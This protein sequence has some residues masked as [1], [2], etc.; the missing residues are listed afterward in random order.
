MTR[1]RLL[2][3]V[4]VATALCVGLAAPMAAI[5]TAQTTDSTPGAY[6]TV[7]NVSM[8]PENPEPGETVTVTAT[9]RNSE[10]SGGA[11]EIT[12]VSLQSGVSRLNTAHDLGS[13]GSGDSTE[14]PLSTTFDSEGEK[15]LTAVVRGVSPSGSVFAVEKPV[16]VDVERSSGV[17]LA[18]SK[19]YDVDAAAGA[20]TP[21]D[22]TVANGDSEAITG[23]QLDVDGADVENPDRITGSIDGG[24]EDTFQYDVT[25]DEVG[26]R[27]LSGEVTYTTA[28]GVTRTT[29]KTAD[30]EAVDPEIRADV[31]ARTTADGETEVELTNFGNARFTDVEVDA[32]ANGDVVAR[33]LLGD[34][35]PDSN[36]SVVFDIPSSIDGT[37]TYTAT[38]TAAGTSHT[39]S[40][41]DR[42]TV[43][44]EIRLVSVESSQSGS[45]VTVTGD[46]AN[47]GSTTAESVLVSVADTA[48]VSPTAPTGEYYVGEVEGS[49]FGTF[50]LT[51]ER[52]PSAESVPVEITYVVDGDRVTTTQRIDL[53]GTGGEPVA[54]SGDG[55]GQGQGQ[56]ANGQDPPGGPGGGLP[57]P[58]IGVALALLVVA[59]GVGVYRWRNR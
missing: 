59:A 39:T 13:L 32:T 26:T 27:T 57:L 28:E 37:V 53:G 3:A 51:A 56:S 35:D 48:D 1:T 12:E 42:A 55:Q 10:S 30:I 46:A 40:L 38:Y 17:S 33:N 11:A 43:S 14:V 2:R 19:V 23:V 41:R 29:T 5:G 16:Y 47:L 58:A 31:S 36:E 18:F 22:V 52:G 6:V 20:E 7:G 25:F 9:V 21:I 44:G 34:V 45:A 24:S 8:S 15:R 50:E 49:E 4:L 54:S